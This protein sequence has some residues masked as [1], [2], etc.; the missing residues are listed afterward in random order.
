MNV[1]INTK[2]EMNKCGKQ[3]IFYSFTQLFMYLFSW[4]IYVHIYLFIITFIYLP[5]HLLFSNYISK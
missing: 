4:F 1:E 5:M 3:C 2:L